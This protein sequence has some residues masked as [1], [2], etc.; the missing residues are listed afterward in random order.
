[1]KDSYIVLRA[2]A[3]TLVSQNRLKDK[4]GNPVAYKSDMDELMAKT[5]EY[6]NRCSDDERMQM[7]EDFKTIMDRINK[8]FGEDAF[9]IENKAGRRRPISMTLFETIYYMLFLA[10]NRNLTDE[11]IKNLYRKLLDDTE[12]M[13]AVQYSV[14]S[15]RN[16]RMRFEKVQNYVEEF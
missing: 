14:D 3:F 13:D 9:R 4:K 7:E 5:M 12:Y 10:K 15:S 1:M 16:V 11:Q 8:V 2:L 6:L